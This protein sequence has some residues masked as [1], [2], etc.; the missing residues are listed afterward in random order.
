MPGI[1][2]DATS[3]P[4]TLPNYTPSLGRVAECSWEWVYVVAVGARTRSHTA[5]AQCLVQSSS[6]DFSTAEMAAPL[7]A[8]YIPP[9]PSQP[10]RTAPPVSPVKEFPAKQPPARQSHAPVHEKAKR[11]RGNGAVPKRKKVKHEHVEKAQERQEE[12]A[13]TQKHKSVLSKYQKSSQIAEAT[14]GSSKPAVAEA[15]QDPATE[16]HGAPRRPHWKQIY[17]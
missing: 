6:A 10:S 8:R 15:D 17:S 5:F 1:V 16:L 7:Y 13:I 2:D 11:K 12:D 4:T 9:H 14:R 3:M